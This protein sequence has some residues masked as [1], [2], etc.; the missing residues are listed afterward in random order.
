MWQHAIGKTTRRI[1]EIG[2]GKG[3]LIYQLARTGYLCRGTEITRERGSKHVREHENLSWNTSDGVHLD[4]FEESASYD[5]VISNQVIEHIH[6]DDLSDHFQGVRTILT[7][8]GRYILTTPHKLVGPSDVS[9]VFKCDRPMGM[10]LKEY[11][12][13]D[14]SKMLRGAGFS[15]VASFWFIPHRIRR[16]AGV[17]PKPTSSTIYLVYLRLL[18][19]VFSLAPNQSLR[20]KI[21]VLG[22]LIMFKG[23]VF[24]VATNTK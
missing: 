1:Y 5:V 11:S 12:N 18:E 16:I 2:S 20:R 10:H 13:G 19:N 4:Q 14:L 24:L 21:A 9:M 17:T 15:K 8:G 7:K 22:R 6:P 23:T 3:A